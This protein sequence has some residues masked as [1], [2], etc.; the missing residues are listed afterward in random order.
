MDKQPRKW[1]QHPVA[2][3]LAWLWVAALALQLGVVLLTDHSDLAGWL[4]S[5]LR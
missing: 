2:R 1:H 3:A 5:A 4:A